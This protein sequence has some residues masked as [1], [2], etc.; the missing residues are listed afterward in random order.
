MDADIDSPQSKL[1]GASGM[2]SPPDMSAARESSAA[3]QGPV[4]VVSWTGVIV[5]GASTIIPLMV[6]LQD[7]IGVSEENLCIIVGSLPCR[8]AVSGNT[9]VANV[10]VGQLMTGKTVIKIYHERGNQRIELPLTTQLQE[11]YE[12]AGLPCSVIDLVAVAYPD[13]PDTE[14]E[15]IE[16]RGNSLAA[17]ATA[18]D[19]H[20]S[21]QQLPNDPGHYVAILITK[22]HPSDFA[23]VFVF[24]LKNGTARLDRYECAEA[25]LEY[26]HKWDFI[27][28]CQLGEVVV[29]AQGSLTV[30]TLADGVEF[31][32]EPQIAKQAFSANLHVGPIIFAAVTLLRD[33]WIQW[34]SKHWVPAV[35][36]GNPEETGMIERFAAPTISSLVKRA[37]ASPMEGHYVTHNRTGTDK[38]SPTPYS[39]PK[40]KSPSRPPGTRPQ[41]GG[42]HEHSEARFA[43]DAYKQ[44]GTG[45]LGPRPQ[46]GPRVR[47]C[48]LTHLAPEMAL[49]NRGEMVES[50]FPKRV[51]NLNMSPDIAL[52]LRPDR[53]C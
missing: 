31:C 5:K 50:K 14:G 36:I 24:G 46:S 47:N 9:L 10:P 33:E 42:T 29:A 8:V 21:F 45:L 37:N 40:I 34:F 16:I 11:M 3:V 4:T 19:Y 23:S 13:G 7:D 25:N 52:A 44:S 20:E 39:P 53:A 1:K 27:D 43:N 41:G 2:L 38:A 17:I 49:Y 30:V 51:A 15:C 26:R 6:Q 35:A 18:E 28:T 48:I 22:S 32:F 12:N